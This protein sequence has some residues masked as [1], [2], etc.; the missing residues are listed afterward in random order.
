MIKDWKAILCLVIGAALIL[1]GLSNG[2]LWNDEAVTAVCARNTLSYGYPRV[3]DGKNW[4]IE[5]PDRRDINTDLA[6]TWNSWLQYYVCAASIGIGGATT[7]AARL[8]F[9]ICGVIG[10]WLAYTLFNRWSCRREDALLGLLLLSTNVPY[11][12]LVR[13]CRYYALVIVFTLIV[14]HGYDRLIKGEKYD[15]ILLVLGGIGLYHSFY[16]AFFVTMAA[17]VIHWCMYYRSKDV[18]KKWLVIC[19]VIA[20]FTLP[21]FIYAREWDRSFEYGH[22]LD[23]PDKLLY[24]FHSYLLYLNNFNVPFLLALAAG[25]VTWR[26]S[27]MGKPRYR[28]TVSAGVAGL[29]CLVIQPSVAVRLVLVICAVIV[30][31]PIFIEG[32][33]DRSPGGTGPGMAPGSRWGS[34]AILLIGIN[35]IICSVVSQYGYY[36]YIAG[37]LP[38]LA[39]SVSRMIHV[40]AASRVPVKI[41]LIIL[42]VL[43]NS[44][45]LFPVRILTHPE[46]VWE[47]L[48]P[49]R[50]IAASRHGEI[51]SDL[52]GGCIRDR[53]RYPVFDH[54][55][56]LT[57]PYVGP[58]E[59]IIGYLSDRITPDSL[60]KVYYEDFTL[61]YY[62]NARISGP[63]DQTTE[64]IPDY[65]IVRPKDYVLFSEK[66]KA[67]I[68]SSRF[69]KV[70]LPAVNLPWNNR[71]DPLFH[72]FRTPTVGPRVVIF[73]RTD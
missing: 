33:G 58:N 9:A 24:F 35:V 44:I 39:F 22:G 48:W 10:L 50:V 69:E 32:A 19:L 40:L 43:T 63:V 37:V 46:S 52:V 17:V 11:I 65:I 30:I 34:L 72:Q 67:G 54:I 5:L 62:L 27:R 3:F 18:L 64:G 15:K 21:F 59:A 56:E 55:H 2:V 1:P 51:S 73:E 68:A 31:S 71:E 36:R 28:I 38:V 25:L 61:I 45:H 20:A 53:W 42:V 14:L 6:R 23:S 7:K 66:M 57:H 29:A 4:V 8:P 47:V 60:L 49:P 12:I 41:T 26:Q 70:V 13:Q 16:V